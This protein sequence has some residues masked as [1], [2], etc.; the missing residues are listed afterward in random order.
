ML[1]NMPMWQFFLLVLWPLLILPSFLAAWAF[2]KMRAEAQVFLVT[3]AICFIP[4]YL[5]G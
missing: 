3:L 1:T 4:Y 5:W 2:S